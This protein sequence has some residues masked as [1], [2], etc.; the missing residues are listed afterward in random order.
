MAELPGYARANPGKI[1]F[2]SNGIGSSAHLVGELIKMAA[3]N[4]AMP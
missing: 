4:I 1:A 3:V 2:G